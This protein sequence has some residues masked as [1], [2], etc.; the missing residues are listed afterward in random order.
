MRRPRHLLNLPGGDGRTG[1]RGT[2][3]A[4]RDEPGGLERGPA[5]EPADDG[6]RHERGDPGVD[7]LELTRREPALGALLQML[8]QPPLGPH[9]Q[10][11]TGVRAEPVGV[12]RA[13]AARG[14]RLA[15][16]GLEIGL[17]EPFPGP[18]GQNC[19]GIRRQPE[20]R[21]DFA[22][23]LLL[24]RGV[25][26]DGLP[27]LGQRAERLHGQRLL[28]DLHGPDV[29][30]QIQGVL[31]GHLRR[32][33][34]GG[35]VGE[36]GEVL[37]QLL[38]FGGLRPGCGDPAHGGQQIRPD[39]VLGAGPAA[40]GL[41]GAG[42]DLGRQVV[43]GVCVAAAG[44]GI[45]AHPVG[46]PAEQFLVRA[47]GVG[48]ALPHPLDQIG[49]RR[50][51]IEGTRRRKHTAAA[52]LTLLGHAGRPLAGR[53]PLAARGPALTGCLPGALPRSADLTERLVPPFNAHRGKP[54]YAPSDQN[55]GQE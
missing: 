28:G 2:G 22:R 8:P 50:R 23:G 38:P 40:Y 29:G 18:A 31:V 37:D 33:R 27:A 39:R 14:E 25:P 26:E 3:S 24:D 43:G 51:Q 46:V 55:T 20:Q 21:R 16:M 53:R 32:G 19:C 5:G 54:P 13:V 15:H 44:T 34:P 10:T 48:P 17:L 45:A 30:P 35:L 42:E 36:E 12:L 41:Q 52:A 1:P 49:V 6:D 9:P 11:A 4:T 47:V 7:V